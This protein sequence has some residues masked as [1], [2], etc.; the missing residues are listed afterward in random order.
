MSCKR[1]RADPAGSSEISWVPSESGISATARR[2]SSARV[3]MSL[4][5]RIRASQVDAAVQP[6][7]IKMPMGAFDAVVANGGCHS[8]PAAAKMTSVASASRIRVSHHGVRAGVSSFGAISSN[9]RVGG[10]SMRRGRGGIN[11]KSHHSTGSVISPTKT[12]GSANPIGKPPIMP[13]PFA[14]GRHSSDSRCHLHRRR[15]GPAKR[16]EV[17][18]RTGRSGGW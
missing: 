12:S 13:S 4:A 10:K 16:A 17:R 18:S 1:T 11:R 14:V 9:R 8:G 6:S 3:M 7:S 2:S 15:F 5:V